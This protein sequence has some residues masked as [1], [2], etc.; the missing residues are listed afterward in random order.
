[1]FDKPRTG[2]FA[3]KQC[4]PAHAHRH[5]FKR[6]LENPFRMTNNE[7]EPASVCDFTEDVGCMT[8]VGGPLHSVIWDYE[9][10]HCRL[11]TCIYS[12]FITQ[13]LSWNKCKW[14]VFL[15]LCSSH[16]GPCSPGQA[17]A[18]QFTVRAEKN[19]RDWW[20]GDNLNVIVFL[21]IPE[22]ALIKKYC[23]CK[24]GVE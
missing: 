16:I 24:W 2:R 6:E 18:A 4:S 7:S 9:K 3:F 21:W 14:I 13:P 1:M 15:C 12:Y 10:D 22:H 23:P 20:M 11:L 5:T 17:A 19:E 8:Q